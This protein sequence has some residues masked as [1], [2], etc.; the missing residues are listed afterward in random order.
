MAISDPAQ[1]PTVIAEEEPKRGSRLYNPEEIQRR[2][3]GR[4]ATSLTLSKMEL[5]ELDEEGACSGEA[6]DERRQ[7]I[8]K[9]M[10]T[11]DKNKDD[12]I[13]FK[14]YT[15]LPS[16]PPSKGLHNDFFQK[17]AK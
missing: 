7:G 16:L 4:K 2:T 5:K 9:L 6:K 17:D 14:E 15:G 10:G 3:L 13:D 11:L 8:D 1:I 12:E